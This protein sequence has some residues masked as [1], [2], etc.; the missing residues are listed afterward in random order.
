MV[1]HMWTPV[2]NKS[3]GI[4]PCYQLVH[5]THLLS[6]TQ[7]WQ[8]NIAQTLG[9]YLFIN[10]L[11]TLLK[12]CQNVC[13]LLINTN[14]NYS[15][16]A[17]YFST[18]FLTILDSFSTITWIAQF[19]DFS[20]SPCQSLYLIFQDIQW[21]LALFISWHPSWMFSWSYHKC[22]TFVILLNVMLIY[23]VNFMA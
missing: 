12:S 6:I 20:H 3:K 14:S 8:S 10:E 4:Y 22:S 11:L 23:L 18:P 21:F 15:P 2:G 1:P 17:V 5:Y 16:S 9:N 7:C 19:H 13:N